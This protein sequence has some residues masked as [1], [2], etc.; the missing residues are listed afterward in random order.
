MDMAEIIRQAVRRQI[1]PLFA[2]CA[3]ISA[4]IDRDESALPEISDRHE[5]AAARVKLVLKRAK[6]NAV[7][8]QLQGTEE[9]IMHLAREQQRWRT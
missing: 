2:D 3:E 5:R 9:R 6:L 7:V 8:C 1:A 4:Q